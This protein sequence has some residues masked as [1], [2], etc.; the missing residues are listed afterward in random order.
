MQ[1]GTEQ[2]EEEEEGVSKAIQ[3]KGQDRC[4]VQEPN[5][6]SFKNATPES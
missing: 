2:E 3:L 4:M 1:R 6:G 5:D